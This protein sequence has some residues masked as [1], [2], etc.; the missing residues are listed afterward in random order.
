LPLLTFYYIWAEIGIGEVISVVALEINRDK[1]PARN[2]KSA[3]LARLL[4][5]EKGSN[6][7][8][9]TKSIVIDRIVN[10]E[11]KNNSKK[12]KK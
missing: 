12:T 7:I 8:E 10:H 5:K 9:S 2:I 1:N 6:I 4:N 11:Q 3:I